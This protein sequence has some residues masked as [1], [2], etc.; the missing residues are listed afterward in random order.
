[1]K[2]PVNHP[3]IAAVGARALHSA[4]LAHAR[5]DHA[6]LRRGSALEI[7][8]FSR[9]RTAHTT[10]GLGRFRMQTEV[11]ARGA[12]PSDWRLDGT[13]VLVAELWAFNWTKQALFLEVME[14]HPLGKAD[15]HGRERRTAAGWT[16][17]GTPFLVSMFG[18]VRVRQSSGRGA[19]KVVFS[20]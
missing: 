14:H 1:M 10:A 5:L 18:P 11:L 9:F 12:G 15:L 16:L 4:A 8:F 6:K 3:D 20:L 2:L 17:P 7:D 13:A 19:S